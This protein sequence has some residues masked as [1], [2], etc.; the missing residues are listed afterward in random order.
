[1]IFTVGW[2]R[3]VAYRQRF[4]RP[5]AA[6]KINSAISSGWE[7]RERWPASSST[8]VAFMRAARNRSKSGDIV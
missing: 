7:T 1:M 4:V 6:A 5:A 3:D 8:V 2:R